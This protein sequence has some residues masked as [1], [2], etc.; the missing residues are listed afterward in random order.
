MEKKVEVKVE[1][2]AEAEAEILALLCLYRVPQT[3][4]VFGA[5]AVF[6]VGQQKVH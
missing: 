1:A 4:V 5:P 6:D 3:P 2:E